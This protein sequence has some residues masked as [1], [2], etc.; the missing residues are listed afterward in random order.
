[1]VMPVLYRV[2]LQGFSRV[3][4][5]ESDKKKGDLYIVPVKRLDDLHLIREFPIIQAIKID[6]ENFEYPVLMGAKN[7][8]IRNRPIYIAS[9][10]IM[11]K[12]TDDK[13]F[14]E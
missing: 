3:V 12:V 13:L 7:L 9:F 6:V 1:M 4:E 14:G 11:K 2:R 8:L 5:N 10:G